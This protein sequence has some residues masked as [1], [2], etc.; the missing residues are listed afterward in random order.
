MQLAAAARIAL[1]NA[2]AGLLNSGIIRIYSNDTADPDAS[3]S[4]TLLGELTFGSTAF[5]TATDDGTFATITA[6]A[7]TQDAS[8]NNG[9][10]AAHFRM[11][12]SDGTTFV[13]KGTVS[14]VGGGGEMQLNNIVITQNGVISAQSCA[15]RIVQGT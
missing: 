6:N 7:I 14:G 10:T 15:L 9:G 3:A 12:R 5:Q 8:A 11:F 1:A 13:T 2:L 4:G